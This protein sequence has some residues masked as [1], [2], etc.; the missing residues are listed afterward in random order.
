MENSWPYWAY[1]ATEDVKVTF[2]DGG[3]LSH[4]TWRGLQEGTH[5]KS[6]HKY[7]G[8]WANDLR[9]YLY[10]PLDVYH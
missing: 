9:H 7:K 3:G 10:I 1:E 5:A 6:K 4:L 2:R 8:V